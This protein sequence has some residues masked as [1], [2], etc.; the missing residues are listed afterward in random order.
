M[1]LLPSRSVSAPPGAADALGFGAVGVAL[2]VLWSLVVVVLLGGAGSVTARGAVLPHAATP[3]ASATA[4][5]HTQTRIAADCSR[6][7]QRGIR[8]RRDW[9]AQ[10]ATAVVRRGL[11]SGSTALTGTVFYNHV[12]IAPARRSISL[13]RLPLGGASERRCRAAK[14]GRPVRWV[15]WLHL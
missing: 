10:A 6:P 3:V 11:L 7:D 5:A 1:V 2:L 13:D 15:Q 8:E 14:G 12:D 4:T 9:R